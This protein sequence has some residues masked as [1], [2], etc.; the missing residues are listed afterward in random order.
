[1]GANFGE[2]SD[3]LRRTPDKKTP[4]IAFNQ[5]HEPALAKRKSLDQSKLSIPR[6]RRAK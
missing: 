3:G 1:M 2:Q 5:R 4:L 6:T